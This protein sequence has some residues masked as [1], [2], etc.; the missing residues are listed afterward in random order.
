MPDQKVDYEKLA[1]QYGGT[2]VK[3]GAVDYVALAKKYGGTSTPSKMENKDFTS[4]PKGEG[5]YRMR[6][7]N[8]QGTGDTGGEIQ[9]PY[10]RVKDAQGSGYALHPD[11]TPR[12][13]KDS[14]HEGEGPSI[15]DKAKTAWNEGT[16]PIADVPL[17]PIDPKHPIASRVNRLGNASQNVLQ[18]PAN[19]IASLERGV[20]GLASLPIQ[21]KDTVKLIWQG[22]PKGMNNLMAFTPHGIGKQLYDSYQNDAKTLGPMAAVANLVGNL[23]TLYAAGKI[24]EKAGGAVKEASSNPAQTLADVKAK[25]AKLA[26]GGPRATLEAVT[27]TTPREIREKAEQVQAANKEA[28]EKAK[29]EDAANTQK[30][31]EATQDALHKTQGAELETEAENKAAVDKAAA[32]HAAAIADVNEHNQRVLDKHKAVSDRI[33]QENAAAEHALNMRQSEEAALQKETTDYFAKED[34]VKDKVKKDADAKW[35]P[36]HTSLDAKTIDGGDIQKPLAKILEISPDVRREISQLIPDPE[37]VDPNSQYAQDRAAIMK[38]Q[39][40][41]G[42]YW[43]LDPDKRAIIDKIASSSGFEPEP[44]DLDPQVGVGIPFDKVHRAQ[45]IIGRNIRNGRY[46]YEGPL[47]GEMTQLRKVL[48]NAESKIAADNGM[49]ADLDE[50]RQATR[51]YQEAFGRP[52]NTPKNQAELRKQKA[53]PEQFKEE[54]EQE[55]VDSAKKHDLTLAA[56]YAKVKAHREEVKKL[57][58]ED[59]LRKAQ[60]QIPPPPT[61]DDL[62]EGYRL[63]PV[64]TPLEPKVK[65][66]ERTAPPDRPEPVKPETKTISPQDIEADKYQN[67]KKQASELRRMGLRRAMYATMTGLPFAVVELF[68]GASAGA[69]EAAIGGLAAGATVFIGSHMLANLVE[70]PDVATWLSKVTDKDV[71]QWEKLP[72]EQNALFTEDMKQLSE[73]AKE[74]GITVSPSLTGFL[75]GAGLASQNQKKNSPLD[76]VKAK[77]AELQDTMHKS[78]LAPKP[79]TTPVAQETTGPQSYLKPTH[80]FN[81]TK[82]IIEAV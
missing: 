75:A 66:P 47:L 81:A 43:D 6:K 50:A 11:E 15:L 7:S 19:A 20:V 39:G 82:G 42:N 10:S 68:K 71:A 5:L 64:P 79:S 60:R 22:D 80:I 76:D 37:D 74:K 30:H 2:T 13:E 1:K 78:G 56:D 26:T 9:V 46:G 62:R 57:Q 54:N 69:G 61:V 55:R 58:T 34:A 45:S 31:L 48:Y 38:S 18:M 40:I 25:A 52:R 70:R 51:E 21:V 4:N 23:T 36:V 65:L 73:A 17:T 59:Q 35:T 41:T 8:P 67:I 77:A 28:L 72:P 53:N 27:N 16:A 63:K 29:T 32:D 14:A 3:K 44:I 49:S 24:G 33:Q 12:F